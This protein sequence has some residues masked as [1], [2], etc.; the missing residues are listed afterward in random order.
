MKLAV[1]GLNPE[2]ISGIW[3]FCPS[4]FGNMADHAP[5]PSGF[6]SEGPQISSFCRYIREIQKILRIGQ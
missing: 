3:V 6:I 1:L 2:T 4:F 5:N